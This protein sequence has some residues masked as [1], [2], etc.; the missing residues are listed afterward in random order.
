[1]YTPVQATKVFE[2]IAAQIEQQ[3][4]RGDLRNGDRLPTE[5]ETDAREN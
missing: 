4:V 1:M 3:I 5:R 2:H